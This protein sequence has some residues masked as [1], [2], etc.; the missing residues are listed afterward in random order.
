MSA[1]MPCGNTAALR[2]H[3]HAEDRAERIEES[4]EQIAAERAV[5]IMTDPA[6]LCEFVGDYEP[7]I[8]HD[9]AGLLDPNTRPE[10]VEHYRR[11]LRQVL[12]DAIEPTL[13]DS[14]RDAAWEE[15]I[16]GPCD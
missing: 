2:A 7:P 13:M 14:C 4:A 15:M 12:A 11:Q 9:L 6:K 5:E 3:E 10:R 16:C 8:W 1:R